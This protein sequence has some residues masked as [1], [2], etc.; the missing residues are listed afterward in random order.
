MKK[1]RR[2]AAMIASAAVFASI[3]AAPMSASA[4]GTT[5]SST[6]I[7]DAALKT[8]TLDKYLVMKADAN[9]PN[10]QFTFS[11]A[12]GA[13]ADADKTNGT[14]AVLAGIGTPTLTNGTMTFSTA[15]TATK[16]ADKGTDTPVFVTADTSDE[17]YVKKTLTLDFSGVAFTEPGIYRYI[18]TESGTNQGITNGYVDA[19]TTEV[20]SRTLDVYVEDVNS[21]VAEGEDAGKPQL[22]IAGYV[23]YN[24]TQTAGPKA[25][26]NTSAAAPNNGA[27]VA[28]AT[29]NQ[30]ISNVYSSQDLTFGKVVT[31]NQGSKDKYFKYTVEIGNISAENAKLSVDLSGADTAVPASPNAATKTDYAGKVNPAELIAAT[32][33]TVDADGYKV[34]AVTTGEAPDTVTTYKI[35]A[36]YYLQNGQYITIQ[37]IPKGASYS[38]TEDEEDYTKT[39]GIDKSL[40]PLNWDGDSTNGNDALTDAA[41]GTIADA[42]IHTGYTNDRSGAIPTGILSTVAGSLGIVAL[43]IAGVAGGAVYLK[44]KKSEDEE[45]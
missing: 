32:T 23:M 45:E 25:E 24:D 6:L 22:K 2:F 35:T 3:A 9:V 29:K 11:V 38:V 39:N 16:E 10:A 15:D 1:S 20:V 34:E 19:S 30:T 8:T 27:E 14:L 18:I 5:Y 36:Y 13:A 31:G 28:D 37:G 42:D 40:S 17:K 7:T 21:P 4:A 33:K 44:K 43:G 41:S 26:T 12:P